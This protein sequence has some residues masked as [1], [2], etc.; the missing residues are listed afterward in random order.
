[1]P[2]R[3]ARRPANT[4]AYIRPPADA[5]SPTPATQKQRQSG[6]LCDIKLCDVKLCDVK[7]RDVK[8][9]DIKLCDVNLCDVKLCDVK[10]C[11][12]KLCDVS[13]VMCQA[14]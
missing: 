2:Q 7:L 14:V 9:C 1:M 8:L 5:A 11:D 6:K 4:K 12:V 13:C 3:P 10:L